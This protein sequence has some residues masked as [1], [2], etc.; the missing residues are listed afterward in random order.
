[1][2]GL[3]IAS[4]SERYAVSTVIF[5]RSLIGLSYHRSWF[6][7]SNR[8]P[9]EDEKSDNVVFIS[10]FCSSAR[11]LCHARSWETFP[12]NVCSVLCGRVR[13]LSSERTG[14]W[15]RREPQKRANQLRVLTRLV[16]SVVLCFY[17]SVQG[18]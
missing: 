8:V 1:M 5:Y 18:G 2:Y 7:V 4:D 10:R 15:L 12:S 17:T 16:W 13:Y 14:E 11:C 6:S 3:T 9:R